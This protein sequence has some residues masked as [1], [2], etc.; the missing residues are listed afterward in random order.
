MQKSDP[1]TAWIQMQRSCI[2]GRFSEYVNGEGR[3]VAAHHRTIARGAGTGIK[4]PFSLYPLT[5]LEH[6]LC[7]QHGPSYFKP[8]DWWEEQAIKYYEKW[9]SVA[10]ITKF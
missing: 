10:K 3:C 5:D 4:P 2:S 7:H 8:H 6:K 1:Y 9:K